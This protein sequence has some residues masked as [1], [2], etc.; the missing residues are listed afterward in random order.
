[1]KRFRGVV[2]TAT[3]VIVA[4]ITITV[5][6]LACSSSINENLPDPEVTD[7]TT[8]TI[9]IASTG[10][11][12][13]NVAAPTF[14]P[15][16]GVYAGPLDVAITTATR[17]ATIHYTLDG[18]APTMLSPT[19]T[20]PIHV[21]TSTTIHALAG[22]TGYVTSAVVVATYQLTVAA[23]VFNPVSGTYSTPL[24]VTITTAAPGATIHY[25]LD[26]TIPTML[27]PTYTGPI[28]V[29]TSTTIHALA[30]ESG[31]VPS[32]VTVA[33][34]QLPQPTVAAPVFNPASGTYSAPL[35]VTITTATPGATIHYTL[36][37]T[38]PTMLSPAYT[39][40]IHLIT[41]TAIHALAG[42]SGYVPS[43]VTVGSYQLN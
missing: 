33:T 37:G 35:D 17:G 13:H 29:N 15:A 38:I 9:D 40:P 2:A 10:K 12:N 30:G 43:T 16:T 14:N 42:E 3:I 32:V 1:M 20:G 36:D 27:S 24:D 11:N 18:T 23:P 28:H 22:K 34:Y 4:I 21:V 31:Y 25:T 41:T 8:P 26:G 7:P 19:Y 39:G 5:S 6:L